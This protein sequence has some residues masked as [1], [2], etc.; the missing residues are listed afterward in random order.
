[1]FNIF[2]IIYCTRWQIG[3]SLPF[4]MRYNV[5]MYIIVTYIKQYLTGSSETVRRRRCGRASA[6]AAQNNTA[7]THAPAHHHPETK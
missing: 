4:S 2:Y 1:M 5:L 7:A 3:V 6:P